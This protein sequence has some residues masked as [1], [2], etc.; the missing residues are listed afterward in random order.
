M[1]VE[2]LFSLLFISKIKKTKLTLFINKSFF[3]YLSIG[4]FLIYNFI[5]DY[6]NSFSAFS[7]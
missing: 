6:N 7:S 4:N 1:R 2:L 5:K 3:L